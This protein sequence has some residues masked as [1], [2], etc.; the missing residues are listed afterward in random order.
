MS[1]QQPYH[2]L[3]ECSKNFTKMYATI[4]LWFGAGIHTW[5]N[6]SKN[7]KFPCK[8]F[9]P[10]QNS[11]VFRNKFRWYPVKNILSRKQ[12][13]CPKT[14]QKISIKQQW[15]DHF[16]QIFVSSLCYSILLRAVWHSKL[17]FNTIIFTKI[18]LLHQTAMSWFSD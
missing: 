16:K 15:S 6:D 11:W 18:H 8:G 4:Q 2:N 14:N 1:P 17:S 9:L 5:R 13:I 10:V 3:F 7:L 12:C